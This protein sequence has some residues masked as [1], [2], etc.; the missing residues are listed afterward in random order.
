VSNQDHLISALAINLRS[1]ILK[2]VEKFQ[3]YQEK[4]GELILKIVKGKSFEPADTERI[5]SD[6]NEQLGES[7]EI[8]IVFADSIPLTVLGKQK[9]LE[10]K[11][12]IDLF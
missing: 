7:V 11:L 12:K 2:N 10:Q 6:L 8:K 5:M 1:G 3:F 9:I 4:K